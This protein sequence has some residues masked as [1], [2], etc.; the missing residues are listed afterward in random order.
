MSPFEAIFAI[1]ENE[2]KTNCV[3]MPLI[4][5]FLLNEL[6]IKKLQKGKLYSTADTNQFTLI[7]TKIGAGFVGDVV[8]YLKDTPCQNLILFGTCGLT[9]ESN[10]LA[11]GS[12]VTPKKSYSLES[13]TDLLLDNR[14]P[15]KTFSPDEDLYHLMYQ[16]LKRTKNNLDIP[17]LNCATIASLK[18]EEQLVNA[19]I[20]KEISLVDMESS[21][22]FSAAQSVRLKAVAMFCVS[23]II[24]QQ[25]FYTSLTKDQENAFV[26][27]FKKAA[28]FL[29]LFIE[30]LTKKSG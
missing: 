26:S 13:F 11:V 23:D 4:P 24:N 19:F 8:L 30:Q 16:F 5:R 17:A 3:L 9:G 14:I 29:G 28:Q 20:Q 27:A 18:L 15:E 7:H 21:A 6:G 12:L 25:P 1:P 2:I 10:N 22:F